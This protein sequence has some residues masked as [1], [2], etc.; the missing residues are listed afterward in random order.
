MSYH[1][2]NILNPRSFIHAANQ[3]ALVLQS[4]CNETR[5]RFFNNTVLPNSDQPNYTLNASN[6]DFLISKS[7]QLISLFTV[8][9]GESR[10]KVPGVVYSKRYE[11]TTENDK[12][13]VILY[14]PNTASS[15]QFAGFGFSNNA[16]VYQV[17]TDASV[18]QFLA[19]SNASESYELMRIQRSSIGVAQVGIGTHVIASNVALAVRSV[20]VNEVAQFSTT[21]DDAFVRLFTNNYGATDNA[22]KG[23]VIGSSNYDKTATAKN[24]FYV[25]NVINGSITRT[26]TIRDQRFGIRTIDPQA[27]LH[28]VAD[29]QDAFRVDGSSITN[30]INVDTHG[31]V[32]IGSA[33][34]HTQ[35]LTVTGRMVVDRLSVGA[36]T[37]ASTPLIIAYGMKNPTNVNY[38]DFGFSTL[39]NIKDIYT[40]F[41]YA[42]NIDN[43]LLNIAQR[44]FLY[45]AT[46]STRSSNAGGYVWF[47]TSLYG[48]STNYDLYLLASNVATGAVTVRS[49]SNVS[50]TGEP[51]YTFV[52]N[53]RFDT[54][55]YWVGL[56]GRGYSGQNYGY[57]YVNNTLTSITIP[58]S[59]T[60]GDPTVTLTG[61]NVTNVRTTVSGIQ[62]HA[63]GAQIQFQQS[64]ILF[65]NMHGTVNAS[66]TLPYALEVG[67]DTSPTSLDSLS[68]YTYTQVF[69]PTYP[70]LNTSNLN[71]VSY[72]IPS[73]ATSRMVTLR[74]RLYN[75]R[76]DTINLP[77]I[78]SFPVQWHQIPASFNEVTME[79]G[80]R[81]SMPI[82]SVVRQQ[83]VS[84]TNPFQFA[85]FSSTS[86]SS[87][88]AI[89]DP[90]RNAFYS[91]TASLSYRTPFDPT[92][93]TAT[94][95]E[96]L[97]L[98]LTT[99]APLVS[100]VVNL[101]TATSVTIQ[102]VFVR[103][104][105]VTSNDLDASVF[106]MD[107][108]CAASTPVQDKRYVVQLP[109]ANMPMASP[110][111][112]YVTIRFTGTLNN[113]DIQILYA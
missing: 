34:E 8:E 94:S 23:V 43:H 35:T 22:T 87:F 72:T 37:D 30:A 41:L 100:F 71:T 7:D 96:Y 61:S 33:P 95:R 52:M 102:S 92:F 101:S 14:N 109:I 51:P 110:V 11:I 107:G 26:L 39:S 104:N 9:N 68:Q 111:D 105:T 63:A 10:V 17:P 69:G 60:I 66:L 78:K 108:G 29:N 99:L 50:F 15:N 36:P 31:H 77:D 49:T 113:S 25:G 65:T 21:T 46:M 93:T 24:D 89:Y 91:S 82:S 67:V 1:V 48:V 64:N 20:G 27:N 5:L 45:N 44:S 28:I 81:T 42:C 38:L 57:W 47:N 70:T 6:N 103:W 98:K 12:K 55:T 54:G 84:A 86:P 62:Y 58:T 76:Y 19:A 4:T 79:V 3:E 59:D 13:S 2:D 73:T 97:A 90:I 16:L 88:D 75:V 106:Y 80:V 18:H 56:S 112:I 40:P 83:L 32:G 85:T 53:G 74:Y